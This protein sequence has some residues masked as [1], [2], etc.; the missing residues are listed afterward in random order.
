[1]FIGRWWGWVGRNHR[2]RRARQK[3]NGVVVEGTRSQRVR[4]DGRR[5]SRELGG[6][7]QE[8]DQACTDEEGSGGRS[9]P[10]YAL[11]LRA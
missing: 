8:P 1:M 7:G 4:E 6:S 10:G 2:H 11:L 3:G 5:R 9:M